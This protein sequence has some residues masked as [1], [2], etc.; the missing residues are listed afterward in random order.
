MIF[1]LRQFRRR[2][3]AQDLIEYGLLIGVVTVTVVLAIGDASM[4]VTN[5]YTTL[6]SILNS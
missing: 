6:L 5:M 1:L 4:I 2:T 3:D